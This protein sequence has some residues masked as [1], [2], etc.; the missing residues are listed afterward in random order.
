MDASPTT[1]S[2]A[3]AAPRV[4]RKDPCAPTGGGHLERPSSAESE[5]GDVH[6][7]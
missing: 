5:F 7:G 1:P 4:V 3:L 2:P 6:G